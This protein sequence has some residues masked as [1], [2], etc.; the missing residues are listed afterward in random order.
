MACVLLPALKILLL[1][2]RACLLLPACLV[3]ACLCWMA[4]D[5]LPGIVLPQPLQLLIWCCHTNGRANM[6][7]VPVITAMCS[8]N[9]MLCMLL[10]RSPS[11]CRAAVLTA[12]RATLLLWLPHDM[13][14]LLLRWQLLLL[15]LNRRA[16][17]GH[18]QL[19]PVNSTAR[20]DA[21]GCKHAGVFTG[22]RTEV[23]WRPRLLTAGVFASD[24]Q[25]LT[26]NRTSTLPGR[27]LLHAEKGMT[28]FALQQLTSRFRRY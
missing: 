3:L 21:R 11:L 10:L 25:M 9:S 1:L 28:C 5:C 2:Q 14:W 24:G 26:G 8:C 27:G 13:M 16:A 15:L 23:W 6:V 17:C 18:V 19:R 12:L 4:A 20:D 22:R 7:H